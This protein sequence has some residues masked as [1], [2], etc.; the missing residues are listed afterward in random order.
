VVEVVHIDPRGLADSLDALTRTE[1]G[2]E[3]IEAAVA[4]VIEATRTLFAVDGVG[5]MLADE[6]LALRYVGATD[7]AARALER[8]QAELGTGPCVESFVSSAV[9]VTADIAH[10]ERWP[11]LAERLVPLGVRA[12]LGVP[13]R[14]AG[15][16]VGTLNV[17]RTEQY[18]WDSSDIAAVEAYNAILEDLLGHAVAARHKDLIVEQLQ[19]A[20]DRRVMI[21]RAVGA[22]M[23]RRGLS[24]QESFDALRRA[25][26]N[27]RR[28][29][30][31]L[32]ALALDGGA[33]V[34]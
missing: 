27:S 31:E 13:S 30:A 29:V 5:L 2:P 12:V 1:R 10:D 14:L 21:E 4:R 15:L 11:E 28:P 25:A 24:A 16:P 3:P 8:A 19:T 34:V 9:T 32:A 33:D 18:E 7:E 26:R 22:I 20:L 6:E 17:Y 23:A